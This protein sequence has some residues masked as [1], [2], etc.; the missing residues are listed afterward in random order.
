MN[1]KKFLLLI[2]LYIGSLSAQSPQITQLLNQVNKDSLSLYLRQLSGDTSCTIGGQTYT[3]VSRHKNQ[4]GNDKAAQFI[5]EKFQSFGLQVQYES[6]SSTGKN[7]I[8]TN[9]GALSKIWGKIISNIIGYPINYLSENPG[10]AMGA[11]FIAGM[12]TGLFKKWSKVKN[13]TDISET[14]YPDKKESEKY[15]KYFN[16]YKKLYLKLKDVFIELNEVREEK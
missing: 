11:A 6:F 8:A 14:I 16:I 15:K 1:S 10:S 13:F 12:G 2:F 9:G 3:I 4:P 5:Y 7:V